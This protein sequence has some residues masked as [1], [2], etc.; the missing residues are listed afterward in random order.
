MELCVKLNNTISKIKKIKS[1]QIIE[2]VFNKNLKIAYVP[3]FNNIPASITEPGVGASTCASGNHKC[4][5]TIGTLIENPINNKIQI[6][7][8]LLSKKYEFKK[9]SNDKLPLLNNRLKMQIKT[10]TEPINV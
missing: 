1:K 7:S 10:K 9:K 3:N 5:G 6:T 8:F 2:Y 4:T